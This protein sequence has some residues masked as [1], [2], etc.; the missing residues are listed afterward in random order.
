MLPVLYNYGC[1]CCQF[2]NLCFW[3]RVNIRLDGGTEASELGCIS[4][5]SQFGRALWCLARAVNSAIEL[6]T[7]VGGGSTLLLAHALA[8]A[9]RMGRQRSFFTM[10]R[11]LGNAYHAQNILES[12]GISTRI[13]SLASPDGLTNGMA[14]LLKENPG[15]WI[16]HGDLFENLGVFNAL[17]SRIGGLDMV[18]L[19]PPVDLRG[20]WPLIETACKPKF[21]AVHN[22]NLPGHAGWLPAH[23]LRT[24]DRWYEIMNGSEA[25]IARCYN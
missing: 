15:V 11:H 10:E 17:C 23:L 4:R 24:N 21:L 20:V 8:K 6:F 18:M 3:V 22:A 7:G 19:D 13:L 2:C 9:Q 1:G 25:V 16:L 12:V 14:A 5:S